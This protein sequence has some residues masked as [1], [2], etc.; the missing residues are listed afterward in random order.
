LLTPLGPVL[1]IRSI[2]AVYIDFVGIK[3]YCRR[4]SRSEHRK[5]SILLV[6]RVAAVDVINR[7]LL[8]VAHAQGTRPALPRL[9]ELAQHA[10]S[11]VA[12]EIC[13]WLRV[14]SCMRRRES[15]DK[16]LAGL[17]SSSAQQLL[18]I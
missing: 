14:H 13:Q 18:G 5:P 11:L 17:S 1:T 10:R 3:A 6:L 16:M 8:G 12:A 4:S 9:S 7:D 15:T 2:S